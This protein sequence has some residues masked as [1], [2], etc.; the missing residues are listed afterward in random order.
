MVYIVKHYCSSLKLYGCIILSECLCK[1]KHGDDRDKCTVRKS[2]KSDT[3]CDSEID[4]I[5]YT[6]SSDTSTSS[7]DHSSYPD[8]DPNKWKPLLLIIPLRLGLTETNV[9]YVESLKV[10]NS[11]LL[12]W[13]KFCV[14]QSCFP[15]LKISS[16]CSSLCLF[17]CALALCQTHL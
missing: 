5:N 17:I 6:A 14:C 4:Y 11:T 10:G 2:S 13:L 1:C 8:I 9:V 7:S 12:I 16:L 3:S 15:Y